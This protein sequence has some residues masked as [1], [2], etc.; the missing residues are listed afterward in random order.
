MANKRVATGFYVGEV[1][2]EDK[3]QSR[4]RRLDL[5]ASR[6]EELERP[7][8]YVAGA[9]LVHAINVALILN[10][11][12]LLT[13]EPGTGKTQLAYSL[14]WQLGLDEPL[15][16]ETKSTSTARDL[17]YTYDVLAR[18]HAAEVGDRTAHARDFITFNALGAAILLANDRS[19]I[20][21]YIT[22]EFEE[23][24]RP[25]PKRRSVVLIDEVDKAPRD[26][27]NDILNEI[28]GMYFRIPE[29]SRDERDRGMPTGVE[30]AGASE[31]GPAPAKEFGKVVAD[32]AMK[33]IVVLTSNSE[34]NLP[35]AFLRRCVY[36]HI[37][38]PDRRA[39]RKILN[40]RLVQ[41][42]GP[43]GR[44][45]D[46]AIKFLGRIRRPEVG[47]RRPAA[48]SEL[49]G[50]LLALRKIAPGAHSLRQ[51]GL[52]G[53][54]STISAIAKNQEDIEPIRQAIREWFEERRSHP[55]GPGA[56]PP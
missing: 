40:A 52:A 12:L 50:W 1:A 30:A 26:F 32:K 46:D 25:G 9:D 56:A 41:I 28:D 7:W 5:P 44:L 48:T 55:G 3:G 31:P 47:L 49:I 27:P 24:Y 38:F 45:G 36:Y 21:G 54:L 42:T 18:F 20:E 13:G 37:P 15:K 6:K 35:D 10:Q 22:R 16:F 19:E 11:P 33:P 29:L 23:V 2:E 53:V 43:L 34:K 4:P 14:A 51:V 8:D 39:L 17:F